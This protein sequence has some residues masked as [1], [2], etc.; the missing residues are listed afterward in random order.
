M[1]KAQEKRQAGQTRL[2]RPKAFNARVPSSPRPS[3]LLRTFTM[4]EKPY[5]RPS[6][7]SQFQRCKLLIPSPH[8]D[9]T[10]QA[11]FTL[12]DPPYLPRPGS[13]TC[14]QKKSERGRECI[15]PPEAAGT[16]GSGDLRQAVRLPVGED[17]NEWIAVNSTSFSSSSSSSSSSSPGNMPAIGSG[18]DDVLFPF[19]LNFFLLAHVYLTVCKGL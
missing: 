12:S 13:R 2:L 6:R 14:K 16:L 11:Q 17:L 18:N 1:G 19:R 15:L 10:L 5:R 4:Q 7:P 3:S 9:R 8:C